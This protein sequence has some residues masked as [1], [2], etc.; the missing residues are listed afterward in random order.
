MGAADVAEI[1]RDRCIG[2]GL[3]VTT[4]PEEALTLQ[5][6]PESE[7]RVPPVSGRDYFMQLAQSRGKTLIPLAVVKQSQRPS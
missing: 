6:K 4:C 7:R 3:C 2:C 1:D 5:S